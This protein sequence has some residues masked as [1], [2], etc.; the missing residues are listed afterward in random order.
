MT[1]C[2]EDTR[3][4]AC[5][6]VKAACRNTWGQIA[7]LSGNP[8]FADTENGREIKLES[9]PERTQHSAEQNKTDTFN[10]FGKNTK[11]HC[12]GKDVSSHISRGWKFC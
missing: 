2:R 9:G 8:R 6:H 1:I 7:T 4:F 12:K 3:R 11:Q 10:L 5:T